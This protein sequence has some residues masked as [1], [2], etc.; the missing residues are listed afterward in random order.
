M[1][2]KAAV[3]IGVDQ[4]GGLDKLTSAAAGAEAVA[5]WLKNEGYDTE[6]L[7]D[8]AE[9]VTASDIKKAVAK[10]VTLPARYNL[11]VVYF[12]GHGYWHARA[13]CWLLSGAPI[14]TSEAIN[15]EGAMD[16]ARFS[17]I[18][19][20]VFISDACRSIPDARSGAYVTGIDAFPNYAEITNKS[21]VD[22]FKATSE[23]RAAFEGKINGVPH[24]ILTY[25]L[26]SAYQEPSADMVKEVIE[27][28]DRIQIVP[29]RK[30]E[31]YLQNKI[32]DILANIDVN[33]S[34][35]IDATVPS[36][37]DVYMARVHDPIM[38]SKN[39][40]IGGTRTPDAIMM[41]AGQDAANTLTNTLNNQN[42]L[43]VMSVTNPATEL[44][45]KN[46][47]PDSNL[48]HLETSVGFT[49][50]GAKVIKAVTTKGKGKATVE[51]VYEGDAN[52]AA[53]VRL[54]NV[55]PAVSVAI[56]LDNGRCVV[57]AGLEGYIGHA[58]F[59]DS[60]LIN[61]S[62]LPSSNH[63]R[64]GMYNNSKDRLDRMRAMIALAVDKNTFQLRNDVE[65]EALANQIRM[66]KA[67]D[68]TLGL[69]AAHA[70]SQ[71]G[72]DER[73]L[74]IRDYMRGDLNIDFFDVWVL[75]TRHFTES[76][77]TL[78]IVPFCPML[79]QTWSLLSPRGIK[80][81]SQLEEVRPYLCN[82]LWTT[83]E[84]QAA[85]IIMQAIET[86]KLK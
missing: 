60:G 13:D 16:L 56:Q 24:S 6:C 49:I 50:R 80:L 67:L 64:W 62:Y 43:T 7:T 76:L 4:T 8:K 22:S 61:V 44:S 9:P 58:M 28:T 66:D 18:P 73:V 1:A 69:Y 34:Q 51:V 78:H 48:D 12:S 10:F 57:L 40:Q 38:M 32:N 74:S 77:Q 79:T 45:L 36:S 5:A 25:A 52:G 81:P 70:Y 59:N 31:T 84:P 20:V 46:R 72:Q 63:W 85:E 41:N 11:L 26:M 3:V 53:I 71:A 39:P 17:G 15:L 30:L 54:H 83:F 55:Q 29:N 27:G 37:D 2:K 42:N 86:G 82:S 33:L 65:A 14:D 68:P 19:N 47:M 21:K 75:I 23:A 35:K